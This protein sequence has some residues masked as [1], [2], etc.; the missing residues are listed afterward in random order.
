MAYKGRRVKKKALH[1]NPLFWAA[2]AAAV[3]ILVLVLWVVSAL[4]GL[5]G[6][7]LHVRKPDPTTLPVS[8]ERPTEPTEETVPPPPANP[9]GP[10]DF[11]LNEETGEITLSNGKYMKGIDVSSWQGKVD[12]KK[13][14]DAGVEFVIIRVGGRGTA[15]GEMYDDEKCQEYYKGAKKAGLKIGAY[16]FAQSL[17]VEEAVEEAEFV[18][19]KVKKWDIDMPL[20][21]DWEYVDEDARTAG[22]DS[23]TLTAMATA[24]CETIEDAGYQPMI[25]FGRS[26]STDML[27]LEELVD[28]PFWL[29][30]Y[31]TIMDY[32]YKVQM[33]QYTD[34]GKLPGISGNVDLNIWF[35]YDE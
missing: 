26:Q 8:Q 7:D 25:Y 22:M 13:V 12:W 6:L 9:Y 14:K 19:D 33:W 28:Y 18:L 15:S 35:T 4:S 24:F 2:V 21:Y 20:V 5:T 23:E 27:K 31:S 10:V 34:Q 11:D 32:P 17:T 3:L 16:V 1:K 30:M 29:A